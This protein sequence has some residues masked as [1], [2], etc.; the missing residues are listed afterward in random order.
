M[1]F[2]EIV[3]SSLTALRANKMRTGL[4]M[5]GII[6]G[7]SSVILIASV[8]Q[9]AVAFIS[10]ELSTFGANYFQIAPGADL[11][12]S[13]AGASGEPLT[14]KD[15][16]AI[17]NSG[18]D[19]IE[20]VAPISFTSR[21]VS[22]SD[23][24]KSVLVYG[25]T[26]AGQDMLKPEIVYGEILTEGESGSRVAIL[27]T[28]V[29][30]DLF[31]ENISPVGE[32]VK[33][34]GIRFRVIGVSKSQSKLAGSFL[35]SSVVIPLE[36]LNNQIKG[37]DE[38]WEIDVS[39]KDMNYLNQTMDDV[40][41]FMRERRGLGEGEVNDF[42]L[43]SLKDSLDVI[44]TVTNM[45]TLLIAGISSISLIVGGVGVMNIM[46]VSVTER[47]K[48]IGLLKSIGAK[49]KDI[50]TQFLIESVVMSLIGG[51]IG[52]LIGIGLA[53][54]ISIAAGI[55]F[56]LSFVWISLAVLASTLVGIVFGLYP[57]RRA[58]R[59]SPIDA[60]RYE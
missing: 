41:A 49:D 21:L 37:D 54:L 15:S 39:V 45:L 52:I 16:D 14:L 42:N 28:D 36:I 40:E 17:L 33:I 2:Q 47:T 53:L 31:G 1:E 38:L 56:I 29:A 50:L 4:T 24:E 27:G 23:K 6:I 48:E 43:T 46:L 12:G 8:G 13:V 44:N 20:S 32:S 9:G 51:M 57:A 25:L 60:L 58:A 30:K 11:F 26:E 3:R 55:P 7:I 18:I 34:E 35:N 19:N 10:N 59:L 5:L 22:S